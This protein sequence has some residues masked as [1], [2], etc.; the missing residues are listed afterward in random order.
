MA[1]ASREEIACYPTIPS[2]TLRG[3]GA[4]LLLYGVI[5]HG[6]PAARADV[7]D[8]GR[9]QFLTSCGTCHTTNRDEPPR[10]G[11]NLA[12]VFGR[13][14]ATLPEYEYSAALRGGNWVWNETTLDP[15]IENA[16]AAHPGTVMNYRQADPDKRRLIIEYL[17]SIKEASRE[18]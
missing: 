15:W 18:L 10:Q 13:R 16:Q 11:P 7:S 14:V 12:T 4:S 6:V 8:A 9:Q 3:A 17:K 1:A 5:L 2:A